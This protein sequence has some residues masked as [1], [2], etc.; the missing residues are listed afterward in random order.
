MEVV[1]I[2]KVKNKGNIGDKVSVKDGFAR[3]FL[4]PNGYAV[5]ATNGILNDL[6]H[7]K[8]KRLKQLDA[9]KADSEKIA[10]VLNGITLKF[11]EHALDDAL[12]G[13][14]TAKDIQKALAAQMEVSV[15][16]TMIELDRPIKETGVQDLTLHLHPEVT[17]TV[18]LDIKAAAV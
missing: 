9:S 13:S 8:Q 10:K 5:P 2:K 15:D 18:K 17:C 6:E 11:V 4:F 7:I 16:T 12:Y 14:I 3:N 1:L